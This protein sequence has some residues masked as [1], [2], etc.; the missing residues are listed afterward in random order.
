VAQWKVAAN[1]S[2][3]G[4]I[5]AR[6]EWCAS[7]ASKLRGLTFR[8]RLAPGSGL[9]LV[10]DRPGRLATAIHMAFVFFPIAVAWLDGDGTVV[11]VR[12]AR[13]WRAYVPRHPAQYVLEA[14][15]GMLECLSLGDQVTF[16]DASSAP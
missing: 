7:F 8:R 4:H 3:E 6:V 15:P 9:V 13:P 10:E 16:D 14:S 11:D 2:R 12:L 1:R 5:L